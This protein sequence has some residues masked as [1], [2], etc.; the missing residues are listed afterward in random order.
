VTGAQ[1]SLA[2][3]GGDVAEMIAMYRRLATM[4]PFALRA[5]AVDLQ[6]LCD[7]SATSAALVATP[8]NQ[9]KARRDAQRVAAALA[10]LAPI[11]TERLTK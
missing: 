5:L 10:A 9:A 7:E 1:S 8:A 3:P 4:D 11:E 6:R 2:D